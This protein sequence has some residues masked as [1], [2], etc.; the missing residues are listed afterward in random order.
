MTWRGSTTP[1]DRVLASLVYLLPL[2]DAILFYSGFG[3]GPG[4][5]FKQFPE[6]QV[7]LLPLQPFLWVYVTILRL[8][9]FGGLG[10]GGLLIFFALFFLVVRNEN[11]RHFIRFN[12]MQSI[13]IG[14]A[15]SLVSI[16][17]FYALRFVFGGTLIEEV[18]FNVL[19]LGT[20]AAVIY[21]IVQSA[22]GRYAEIPTIS[23]AAYMQ[24]R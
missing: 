23:E 10:L 11:I 8:F 18:I 4:F 19:F 3:D 14:I 5:F 12:T 13:V 2:M 9:S 1:L 6:L 21:S 17:W 16:I 20:V 24:V 22:L 15:L 7:V